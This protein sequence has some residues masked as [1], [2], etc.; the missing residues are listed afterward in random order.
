M[1]KSNRNGQAAT[2]SPEQLDADGGA[3][4]CCTGGVFGMQIYCRSGFGGLESSLGEYY[5]IR[6]SDTED[7]H[8]EEDED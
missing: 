6:G 1:V 4:A 5:A 7:D 3:A 2:L 8:K